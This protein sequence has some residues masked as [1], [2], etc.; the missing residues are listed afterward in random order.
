MIQSF[1]LRF[2]AIALITALLMG[3]APQ[4][5]AADAAPAASYTVDTTAD[6]TD[7]SCSDGDCSLRDA[8]LLA[9]SN[10]GSDTIT[11]GRS[12]GDIVLSSDLPQITDD[13]AVNGLKNLFHQMI[14][15]DDLYH[16]FDVASGVMFDLRFVVITHGAADFGGGLY[17]SNCQATVHHSTFSYNRASNQ[18]GAIHCSGASGALTVTYGAFISNTAASSGGAISS[19]TDTII[20]IDQTAFT[21]NSARSQ[22]GAVYLSSNTLTV[23]ASE[24]VSN[25]AQNGGAIYASNVDSATIGDTTFTGNSA[26]DGNGGALASQYSPV[27]VTASTFVTNSATD[28][29]GAV[30]GNSSALTITGSDLINNTATQGGAV[31]LVYAAVLT[32]TGSALTGNSASSTGG[33][34]NTHTWDEQEPQVMASACTFSGNSASSSGGAIAHFDGTLALSGV[35]FAGNNAGNN[36]SAIYNADALTL[37]NS[38]LVDND[39]RP[40][41]DVYSGT[42]TVLHSTFSGNGGAGALSCSAPCTLTHSIVANSDA[43]NCQGTIIDGGHNLQYGGTVVNSCGA[44]IETANPNLGLLADNGGETPTM[45][46]QPGSAALDR[47]AGAGGCGVGVF[48]DQRGVLRPPG[49]LCDIGAYEINFPVFLPLVLRNH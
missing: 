33:A 10:A 6:E 23:T 2:I 30:F 49:G 41:L 43:A 32:L 5:P 35:T 3:L 12:L 16:V 21:G 15:G 13:L 24:F 45:A 42:V 38:T 26:S 25:T 40:A 39:G 46:P 28:R 20:T 27:T 7:G 1:A 31:G 44:S 36:G 19:W 14:S 9:N 29:G 8:I 18:G 34:I 4:A 11:F 22:G 48:V 47:I 37:T 17:C